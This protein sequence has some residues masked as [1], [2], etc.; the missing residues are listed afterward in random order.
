MS[1]E[2]VEVVRAVFEAW[3][4]GNMDAVCELFD[5]DVIVRPAEGWPAPG[6]FVGREAVRR[7]LTQRREAWDADALEAISVIDAG[8]RV[9]VRQLWHGVGQGPD[10]NM[11]LTNVYTV[12]NG[13]IFGMESFWD[14]AK[15]L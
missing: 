4:A 10:M 9:V 2:N 1:R 7:S 11:Q 3:N 6:P 15:A 5:P 8:D 14:H 13:M 12:R